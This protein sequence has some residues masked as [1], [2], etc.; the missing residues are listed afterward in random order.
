MPRADRAIRI[1]QALGVSVEWLFGGIGERRPLLVE[2]GA[3]DWVDLPRY[4][5][6]TFTETGKGEPED[7]IP[8]RRDLLFRWLNV[9]KDLWLTTLPSGNW[10]LGL[11]SGDLVICTDITPGDGPYDGWTCI[12]KG[13]AAPFIAAYS[14]LPG[15]Q[16][17]IANEEIERQELHPLARVR[18]TL[19]AEIEDQTM[20]ARR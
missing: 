2:A 9:S 11:K 10:D 7:I 17:A 5:L 20:R 12:W 4:E 19:I 3:A 18:A 16:G 8:F 14:S 15:R 6:R 1:A 13:S